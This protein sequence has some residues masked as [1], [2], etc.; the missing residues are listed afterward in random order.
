MKKS[1]VL[2]AALAL[3]ATTPAFAA[4]GDKWLGIQGGGAIPLSDL[5]DLVGTG[6]DGSVFGA[7]GIAPKIDIGVDVGYNAWSGKDNVATP[8]GPV[9]LSGL[10]FTAI[11]ATAFA[12]YNLT[13]KGKGMPYLKGGLGMYNVKGKNG[14]FDEST[15]KFGYNLGGGVDWLASPMYTIGINAA[16]HQIQLDDEKFT[17]ANG[18]K[19]NPSFVTVGVQLAWGMGKK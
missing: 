16:Y 18:E 15:S 7:F 14:S 6:W 19:F 12:R 10:D 1:M 4:K 11:Q 13:T 9:D 8:A 17:N 2:L 5:S 3:F